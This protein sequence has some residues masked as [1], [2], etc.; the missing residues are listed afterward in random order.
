[1]NLRLQSADY[2]ERIDDQ[3][4]ENQSTEKVIY[5]LLSYCIKFLS[6]ELIKIVS[7][8]V[9]QEAFEY[10]HFFDFLF[11]LLDASLSDYKLIK[12]QSGTSLQLL[13]LQIEHGW[14]IHYDVL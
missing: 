14:S 9:I 7:P 11:P 4:T 12:D 10:L 2:L 1:M 5:S 3:M 8:L 6:F 13:Y